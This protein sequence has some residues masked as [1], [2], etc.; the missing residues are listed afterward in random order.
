MSIPSGVRISLYT[1]F[2]LPLG[3]LL[4]L[5]WLLRR[6]RPVPYGARLMWLLTTVFLGPLGLLAY[7]ITSRE[8]QDAGVS[9]AR[10][11]SARRALGSASWAAAGNLLGGLGVHVLLL[12]LLWMLR[13]GLF[14]W[15]TAIP[16][17]NTEVMGL[18]WYLQAVL[19]ALSFAAMLGGIFLA[20]Q[21]AGG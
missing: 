16:P 8:H 13:R 15:S 4:T 9:A 5:A 11:S 7:W 1:W 12:Y 6:V 20:M 14:R 10:R 17:E 19:V 3:S 21:I 2:V 18:A